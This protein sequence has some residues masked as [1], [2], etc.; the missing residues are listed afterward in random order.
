M[1]V[2]RSVYLIFV[3]MGI[4]NESLENVIFCMEI[5][6]RHIFELCTKHALN[7][8]DYKML[9]LRN[10]EVIFGKSSWSVSEILPQMDFYMGLV[11]LF[12]FLS[13][14]ARPFNKLTYTVC[15]SHTNR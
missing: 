10:V 8:G 5:Q 11:L 15:I 3:L 13:Q 9:T 6:H 2:A 1:A 14:V 4:T 12:F 7:V